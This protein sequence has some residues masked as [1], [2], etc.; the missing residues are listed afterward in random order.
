MVPL[1]DDMEDYIRLMMEYNNKF[2]VLINLPLY[3]CILNLTGRSRNILDSTETMKYRSKLGWEGRTGEETDWSYRMQIAFYS[4]DFQMATD[5]ANKLMA[6][7]PGQARTFPYYQ[8]RVF[9]FVLIA[10]WN[11]KHCPRSSRLRKRKYMM[12]AKK[13]YAMVKSWVLKKKAINMAH[14][15]RI[16]D[17]E[18]KSTKKTMDKRKLM[19][20]YDEAI[21]SSAR[22]G[23]LNDAALAAH[24]ASRTP[25]AKEDCRTRHLYFERALELYE[26]WGATGL[27]DILSEKSISGF[28]LIMLKDDTSRTFSHR[29]REQGSF[30]AQEHGSSDSQHFGFRSRKR[31]DQRLSQQHKELVGSQLLALDDLTDEFLM[32]LA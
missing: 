21:A 2:W 11:V 8:T 27:L 29:Y 3:Q 26:G 25:L 23:F 31:F 22:C 9:F 17:V 10:L 7:A 15:L 32:L 1:V 18:M 19:L 12:I 30:R 28:S 20:A 13:Y 4:E 24:L 6:I 14:K 16:L 5:Y